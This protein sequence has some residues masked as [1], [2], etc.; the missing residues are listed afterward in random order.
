MKTISTLVVVAFLGC[1]LF[2]AQ[3]ASAQTQPPTKQTQAA[4]TTTGSQIKKAS[5]GKRMRARSGPGCK[6]ERQLLRAVGAPA[7]CRE[8][9]GLI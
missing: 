2:A 6:N 5:Y 3:T 4:T 9:F 8:L 7:L 1:G